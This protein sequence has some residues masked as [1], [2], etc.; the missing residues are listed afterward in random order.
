MKINLNSN[1]KM[2]FSTIFCL[3]FEII[4]ILRQV[5]VFL[6]MDV[7]KVIVLIK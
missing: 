3:F 4:N 7:F 2:S 5:M 1:I 6:T